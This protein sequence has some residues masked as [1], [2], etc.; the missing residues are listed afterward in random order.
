MEA[1]E[2]AKKIFSKFMPDLIGEIGMNDKT[3]ELNKKFSL[4]V[5]NEI[6]STI[7]IDHMRVNNK[8]QTLDYWQAVR[9]EINKL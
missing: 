4:I 2:K 7:L 9:T 8:M 1:K 6:I 3:Y 5:V